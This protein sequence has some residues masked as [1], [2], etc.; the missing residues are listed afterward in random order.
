MKFGVLGPLHARVDA[1]PL[2]LNGP[3]QAKMLAALLLDANQVVPLPR[4]VE[5]MWDDEGP[6]TAVRQVQD[7]IS[8]LR[9]NLTA[10]GAPADLIGTERGGYRIRVA[11]HQLDLLAFAQE[12]RAAA[13]CPDGAA[14]VAALRRALGHWRGAAL[15][16]LPG[17]VLAG[18]ANRL[19]T[20]RLAVHRRC[21]DLELA[22]GRHRE[23]ADELAALLDRHPHDEQLA[24]QAIRALCRD[25]RRREALEVYERT[26]RALAE[27]LGIDP[28][29]ALRELQQRVLNA[30]PALG[31]S[32]SPAAPAALAAPAPP[33]PAAPSPAP[34][35]PAPAA[36][37]GA[38]VPRQLSADLADFTGREPLVARLR[39][40]LTGSGAPG[41][42]VVV[43]ALD[44]TGGIGKT[45]LAVHVA[46][47]VLDRFPDGQL[48]A[49]LHGAGGSP[50]DPGELLAR[51]LR[52]LGL[53]AEEI[54]AD[55][56][57]RQAL[58]RST[59][60]GRRVL[61]LLDNVR[62][63][64][65]VRPLLP[66]SGSCAVLIT[67]RSV[68][69][70]LD[71]AHR[72]NVETLT[73]AEALELFTRIV[74]PE[75]VAGDPVAVTEV[76]AACAGLPLAI[77]LAASRLVARPGW[78]VTDLAGRLADER[79]RLGELAVEDRAVRASFAVS[80]R[81]LPTDQA[82]TFRR[83]GLWAGPSISLP[84]AAALLAEPTAEVEDVLDALADVHLLQSPRAGRYLLHDL[85]RVY[86][87]ECALAQEPA[88]ERRAATH[89]MLTWYLHTSAAASRA[90]NPTRR[91]VPL[92]QG[93][94]AARPLDFAAPERALAW[95]ESEQGNLLAAVAEAACTGCHEIAWKLPITMW[96]L[97][98]QR[99]E[100]HGWIDC[101]ETALASARSLG[102]QEAT[103][104][105]L[106]NLA[107][108]YQAAGRL[109]EALD[110][111]AEAL[112]IRAGLGDV[113]G[114]ASCL[115]NLGYIQVESGRAASAVGILE[116]A[117]RIFD[118]IGLPIGAAAA[119]TNLGEA[120][121]Q[122][123]RPELALTHFHAALAVH[124]VEGD[125][126]SIGRGLSNVAETLCLLGRTAEAAEQAAQGLVVCR[127]TGNRV[128]EA[129]ALDVLGRVHAATGEPAAAAEHWRAA[130]AIFAELG[131]PRAAQVAARL[132][133]GAG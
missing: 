73:D 56:E 59:L 61:L 7:A 116:R 20:A 53:A 69:P 114:E 43:S 122:L 26:R 117:V 25:G 22:L 36:P 16:D 50:A 81:N 126:F 23:V 57:E 24:E 29:P 10:L 1:Q 107:I 15:A 62:D 82:R 33:A 88:A 39:D 94:P 108:A 76:L 132:A 110:C 86:A 31:G 74:G 51:F 67:S 85:L 66:G 84:A 12:R 35:E 91:H 77:R 55:P 78:T 102:D 48:Q 98:R 5:V 95:F 65:Q 37:A 72:L 49:D 38:V 120:H 34:E 17:R 60:A 71:G 99:T 68:L 54:P 83:L 100:H 28:A 106:N 14:E 13:D 103:G 8:G 32:P 47:Q 27:E 96:D 124:R 89:R 113:R 131:E 133:G 121:K 80:Y 125:G 105:V 64:A 42:P 87:G 18:E 2:R 9:R 11:T 41:A 92:D 90:I 109:P 6:A 112:D 101:T 70:G 45:S 63:T 111:L 115:I 104:W 118:E 129:V 93:P 75:R 19:E 3:R 119:H 52:G 40:L 30:D 79:D 4:L 128:D 97:F 44:G 46:H 130:H 21:L 127:E 58:Y 123:G